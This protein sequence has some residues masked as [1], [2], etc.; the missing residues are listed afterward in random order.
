MP[1]GLRGFSFPISHWTQALDSESM[2]FYAREFPMII[3]YN[4]T[5][6][7]KKMCPQYQFKKE[8]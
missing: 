6:K 8:P 1:H 5:S 4:F 3:I 7:G 2:E